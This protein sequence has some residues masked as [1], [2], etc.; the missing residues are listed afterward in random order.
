LK[1]KQ[2]SYYWPIQSTQ[3]QQISKEKWFATDNLFTWVKEVGYYL[4]SKIKNPEPQDKRLGAEKAY[5]DGT[6]DCEEFIDLFITIA[7]MRGIPCRRLTGYFIRN[8][9]EVPE[10]HA[11][12]EVLSPTLGWIPIDIAL[13]NIGNHT[14]NYVIG[15]IEEFNPALP[16]Y[17]IIQPSASVQYQWERPLPHVTPIY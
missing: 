2:S 1:Y 6:G 11:W 15:K 8:K 4:I 12:G 7:R 5:I 13:R 16:D 3:I 10:P 9:K 14:I 17:T